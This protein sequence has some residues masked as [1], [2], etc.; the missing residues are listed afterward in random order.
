[1]LSFTTKLVGLAACGFIAVEANNPCKNPGE[2]NTDS[3]ADF[4]D[5]PKACA[6]FTSFVPANEADCAGSADTGGAAGVKANLYKLARA[7]CGDKLPSEICG[8]FPNPCQNP[9][10]FNPDSEA[11]FGDGPQACADFT[12]LVPANE[13]DCAGSAENG[14][15]MGVKSN[16]YKLARACCGD[17]LPSEVCG[18]FPNP[19]QNPSDFTPDAFANEADDFKCYMS[20]AGL[21][22]PAKDQGKECTSKAF[23]G[24]AGNPTTKK[25]FLS[26]V[27]S[28]CCGANGA[29]AQSEICGK[30][31]NPCKN[32]DKYDGNALWSDDGGDMTCDNGLMSLPTDYK[33]CAAPVEDSDTN[34]AGVLLYAASR[35]CSDG[36][37]DDMCEVGNPCKTPKNF[38]GSNEYSVDDSGK[39]Y[40][41][42]DAQSNY[43]FPANSG[44]CAANDE[45][46]DG[47]LDRALHGAMKCCS[48]GVDD[49]A[50]ACGDKAACFKT[51]YQCLLTDGQSSAI[52][53]AEAKLVTDNVKAALEQENGVTKGDCGT[54]LANK[55]AG[56]ICCTPFEKFAK[57][58]GDFKSCPDLAGPPTNIVPA[59]VDSVIDAFKAGGYCVSKPWA[60][61]DKAAK[62]KFYEDSLAAAK[63]KK[64][65]CGT[66]TACTQ[67]AEAEI[68]ALET[69]V[70][71]IADGETTTTT[72]TAALDDSAA[73]GLG[74]APVAALAAFSMAAVAAAVL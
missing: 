35:C 64:A 69:E 38:V 57:C 65:K 43:Q 55:I 49:M 14:G 3:E 22:A 73:F 26:Q 21:P 54:A 50:T 45:G 31:P 1:M 15:A 41:C 63:E 12:S 25:A 36:V 52:T 67:A 58:V 28:K 2:F 5:G 9:G 51:F 34:K 4:G 13:A 56:E 24:D 10:G 53:A 19:C 27:A 74:P 23:P 62:K 46:E 18:P 66:D 42:A 68:T 48:G 40:T 71:T 29:Q 59:V 8:P 61:T 16:L 39:K 44:Q 7:C 17:K 60:M 37:A 32:K 70:Q 30:L 47:G 20:F 6:D 11:D 72:T 33:E